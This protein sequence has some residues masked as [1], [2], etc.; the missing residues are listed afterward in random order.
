MTWGSEAG[1]SGGDSLMGVCLQSWYCWQLTVDTTPDNT[2]SVHPSQRREYT[3]TVRNHLGNLAMASRQK[4]ANSSSSEKIPWFF[5][6]SKRRFSPP[7]V[8]PGPSNSNYKGFLLGRLY[9]LYW[10][11]SRV[12]IPCNH[13][14][15][16]FGP[17]CKTSP[18]VR[19]QL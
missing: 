2:E 15:T 6:L 9:P 16:L 10:Y 19:M 5:M 8:V 13:L 3:A 4:S 17:D 7:A 12:T 1:V 11:Q 14:Y 18:T